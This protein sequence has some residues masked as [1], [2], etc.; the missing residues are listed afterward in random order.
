MKKMIALALSL[1][2]MLCAAA[3][4]ADGAAEKT[5]LGT[6]KVGEAFTIQ[7]RIPEGY[8]FSQVT[9]TELNLIGILAGGEGKPT[10]TVS[11]AYNEE[12][13]GVER[14]NDVDEATVQEIRDSFQEM[15]DVTFE[16]LETAYGTR[17]LKVTQANKTFADIYTIYKGYE[18]EF[19]MTAQGEVQDADIQMLVD[20]IS[21]MD[22]ISEAE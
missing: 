13:E 20:F 16:D 5:S 10:V 11:I 1:M 15:D 4:V 19:I 12:Y 18:L 9:S 17:L 22:F 21:D 6:L 2:L 3:A 7:S 8:T 14:F